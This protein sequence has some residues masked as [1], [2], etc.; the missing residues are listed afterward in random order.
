MSIEQAIQI[1]LQAHKGQRDKAGAPYILHPLRLMLR[2]QNEQEMITAVLHD[3]VEDSEWTLDALRDAGIAQD[4]LDAFDCLTRREHESYEEF[5]ARLAPNPLAR[6]VKIADLEDNMDLRRLA[7]LRDKDQ[8]R[9]QRYLK[10]WKF[11]TGEEEKS[12]G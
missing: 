12:Q 11:L 10:A 2:M 4:I 3:V 9:L 6:K 1:A 7:D 5:I 8:S